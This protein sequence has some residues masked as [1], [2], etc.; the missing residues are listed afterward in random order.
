VKERVQKLMAQANIGSR[1]ACEDLIRQG[2]VRVNGKVIHLGDQADPMSD[3]IEVD[4]VK[5][6]FADQH[7]YIAFNK[8]KNVVSSAVGY[9]D[10]D[11]RTVREMFPVEGHLFTIGRLDADSEGLIIL[12]NDGDMANRLSHPRYRHTKTYKVVVNGLPSADTLAKWEN[13][14][15]IEDE[16]TGK[17]F[18][19]APCSVK[20]IEGS[21]RETTLRI[22]MTEGKKRQIRRV[23]AI[24]GHPVRSLTRTHIGKLALGALRPGEWR[25]LNA[26]DIQALKTPSDELREMR[27]S[28]RGP[29]RLDGPAPRQRRPETE[30]GEASRRGSEGRSRREADEDENRPRGKARG[31]RS[32]DVS[33]RRDDDRPRR[34]RNT[35]S[36]DRDERP[37][38]NARSEARDEAESAPRRRPS[39]TRSAGDD[40]DKP[41]R[42][43]S[44]T[45]SGR[46]DEDKPRRRPSTT[47]SGR[48][49]EDKPRRRPSTTRT[50]RDDDDKPRR[51]PSTTRTGR[52]DEDKPRRRPSTSRSGRD[53]E[54]KPRRR[55]STTRSGRDDED[56]P[57][58]R[59]GTTRTRRNQSNDQKPR[60]QGG[61]KPQ[62]RRSE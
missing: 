60:R 7:I 46:D 35:A 51:R 59:P 22:V 9:K 53:D 41:R 44:T 15:H 12:T 27:A 1:R 57:R 52:D 58:R 39:T 43:P 2:R 17:M 11:R 16:E 6:A 24:L 62:R 29:V 21:T 20:I 55:P 5:L 26:Q 14:I 34:S 56:K 36:S 33:E 48:D 13:G 31:V 25:E 30:R 3:T 10:D 19:T 45:R 4:G 47:R 42:R 49:D 40:D 8:P 18:K 32:G 50:G 54:D 28:R 37:R 61:R 23:A 38:R